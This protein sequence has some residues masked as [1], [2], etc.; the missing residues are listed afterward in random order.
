MS[1]GP[2]RPVPV[3]L[4]T[5]HLGAAGGTE[6]QLVEIAK[7][8]N[9]SSFSPHVACFSD[10]VRGDELRQARV[11]I[12]QLSLRSFL[13]SAVARDAWRLARYIREHGIQLVHAFDYP[14]ICFGVPVAK[15]SRAPVVL[16]SQRAN[17]SLTPAHYRPFQRATDHM[18]D[19]I[20]ANCEAMRQHLIRDERVAPELIRICY[21]GIDAERFRATSARAVDPGSLTVGVVAML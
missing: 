19:G 5:Q 3:M 15:L 8:I 13:S 1:G 4:M 17:R 21:N 7:S 11:P 2:S 10:G 14:L 6:R 12:L 9:R 20:V 16:S 18:V